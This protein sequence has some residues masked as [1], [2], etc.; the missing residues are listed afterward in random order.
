MSLGPVNSNTNTIRNNQI[1]QTRAAE[2]Q[3]TQKPDA[4]VAADLEA[5]PEAQRAAVD[6]QVQSGARAAAL[7][8]EDAIRARL[9]G[10]QGVST[11]SIDG[12]R[13]G[14]DGEQFAGKRTASGRRTASNDS[15]PPNGQQFAALDPSLQGSTA[16]TRRDT[17]ADEAGKRTASGR[18]RAD[19]VPAEATAPSVQ[20]AALPPGGGLDTSVTSSGIDH[21]TDEAGKRTS[22]GRRVGDANINVDTTRLA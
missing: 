11:P 12:P 15:A 18:R 10:E 20:L 9:N 14:L 22:S 4:A 3:Q 6:A 1:Q 16:S 8:N 5:A 17:S 13:R 7:G 21:G 19:A 2:I